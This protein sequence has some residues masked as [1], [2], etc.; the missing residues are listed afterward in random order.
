MTH[1]ISFRY[2]ADMTT[3]GLGLGLGSAKAEVLHNILFKEKLSQKKS[4][5]LKIS[6]V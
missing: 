5:L 6:K 1:N 3:K 4:K 2:H